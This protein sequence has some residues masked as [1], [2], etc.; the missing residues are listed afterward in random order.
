[1]FL[2]KLIIILA[3]TVATLPTPAQ[4]QGRDWGYCWTSISHLDPTSG[5]FLV[6]RN[7]YSSVFTLKAN[8]LHIGVQNSFH[9][10]ISALYDGSIG[11]PVCFTTI[12]GYQEAIDSRNNNISMSRRSGFGI[13]VINWSYRG[14][15]TP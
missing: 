5:R 9:S 12:S 1:M 14:E 11:Q 7:V 6:S 10:H 8:G 3:F 4:P 2:K 15:L 13:D